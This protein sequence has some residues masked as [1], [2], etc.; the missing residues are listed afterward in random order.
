MKMEMAM[1]TGT[2]TGTGM[3]MGP[4]MVPY[5]KPSIFM[6]GNFPG[7]FCGYEKEYDRNG[8]YHAPAQMPDE[9]GYA[10]EWVMAGIERG[11]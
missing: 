1:V 9:N 8:G 11:E 2:G 7:S 3:G 4:K 6:R 10:N 5:I